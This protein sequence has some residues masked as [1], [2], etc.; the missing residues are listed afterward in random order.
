[1]TFCRLST[2]RIHPGVELVPGACITA[3]CTMVGAG[4]GAGSNDALRVGSCRKISLGKIRAITSKA[5]A[6]ARCCQ[7]HMVP[8]MNRVAGRRDAASRRK[9]SVGSGGAL[10]RLPGICADALVLAWTLASG[11]ATGADDSDV[12]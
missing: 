8:H 4:E 11:A 12:A 7:Y 2:V 6:R 1:M 3:T 10:R 5:R 9:A